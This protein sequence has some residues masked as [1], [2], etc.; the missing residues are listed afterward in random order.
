MGRLLAEIVNAAAATPSP[1]PG[2]P[3]DESLVTPGVVGFVITGLFF[4]V[5]VLLALDMARRMRRVRYRT[6]A[7]EKI[8]AELE[9]QLAAGE[10]PDPR[11]DAP[12]P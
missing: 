8:A 2:V 11:D 1:T 7:R 5:V 10:A 9:E 12:R 3:P 4:V 6:E